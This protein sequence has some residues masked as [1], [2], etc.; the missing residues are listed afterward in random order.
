[1][2]FRRGCAV[3][4]TSA[5]VL[6][7]WRRVI[8]TNDTST[9]NFLSKAGGWTQ[10]SGNSFVPREIETEERSLNRSRRASA[11]N[12]FTERVIRVQIG[13]MRSCVSLVPYIYF[14]GKPKAEHIS[15]RKLFVSYQVTGM[16][17]LSITRAIS[18]RRSLRFERYDENRRFEIGRA[19]KCT[20]ETDVITRCSFV[21]TKR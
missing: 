9:S 14:S 3:A 4:S 20:N 21:L 18:T 12:C 8:L 2:D 11:W 6:T 17:V 10:G 1:M 16:I 15:S 7:P 5:V 13:E 19:K